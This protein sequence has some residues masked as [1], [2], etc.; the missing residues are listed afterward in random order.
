MSFAW[1]FGLIALAALVLTAMPGAD[2]A[3]DLVLTA[4]MIAFFTA[5][6]LLGYRLY[7]R[8]HFELDTLPD[9]NRA[10]LYGSIGLVLLTLCATSRL[11]EIGGAGVIVWLA[12]LAAAAWGTYWVYARY[13]AYE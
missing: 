4:L 7:T 3:I 9:R 12:L 5:I 11:F 10:V 6:A 2:H 1:K 8:F 13:R